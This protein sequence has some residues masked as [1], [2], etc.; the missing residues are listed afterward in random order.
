MIEFRKITHTNLHEI[1]NLSVAENQSKFVVPNSTS[2]MDAYVAITNDGVALPF[3]IYA[4]GTAVGFI[5][6]T[7][8]HKEDENMPAIAYHNYC[9]W[10]FMIDVKYQRRGYGK[11]AIREAVKYMQT[12]P[13]GK[14]KYCW[15]NY[16]PDNIA[17]KT[18]Y[19]KISKKF[20]L[21]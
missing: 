17:A 15:L 3:G 18:F 7:Y 6:F 11:E 13:C 19:Q 8:G 21:L 14:A 12:F 20:H 5:M 4:E 16:E 9:I 2:I 1:I 10:R